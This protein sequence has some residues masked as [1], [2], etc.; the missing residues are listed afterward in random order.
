MYVDGVQMW[1]T[2]EH[3]PQDAAHGGENASF[4]GGMQSNW[5]ASQQ[6]GD[7]VMHVYD[8]S[9]ARPVSSGGD[10]VVTPPANPTLPPPP[11]TAN[12][13]LGTGSDTVVLKISQDAWQGSAQ[14][15]VTVDGTQIGGTLTATALHS[16]GLDDTVTLHGNW[17][18][19]PHTLTVTF[20]NDDWGGSA[21]TDRN[22]YVDSISFNGGAVSGTPIGMEQ[23]GPVNFAFSN[24][25]PTPGP[26]PIP[27]SV[28]L[29]AGSGSDTMVL[30]IS[31]D[32][33]QGSAQY[34]VTVDG[35]QV[36]GTFT[37]TA[38]HGSGVSD[39]L[40]L[41]GDWAAGSHAVA[42]N[43]LNDAWG[44]TAATDRNLYVDSVTYD[45]AAVSGA[46]QAIMG[47]TPGKFTVADS[48]AIPGSTTPAP[49][50]T[51]KTFAGTAGNDTLFATQNNDIITGG[52][53]DDIITARAGN[54]VITGGKG[55]DH[56]TGGK[57][58]DQFVFQAGDGPD[59]IVDFLAGTDQLVLKGFTA[60]QVTTHREV[61]YGTSGLQVD[62]GTDHVFL[63]GTSA[64]K[65]GDIV[66]A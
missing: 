58:A 60:S 10:V 23:N 6:N 66:F 34:T 7:N 61:Y 25:V 16:A 65:A 49:T 44:G 55:N 28:N 62:Y 53:G 39:T 56:I 1:T 52:A 59:W 41:K 11:T 2:T 48:T 51:G 14:Y 3:V 64:L 24:A 15:I 43:F 22:L 32:A 33:W 40:T 21:D 29:A 4:G 27:P 19:G 20:I 13:S 36:G 46:T 5:A 47:S 26:A 18:A 50:P 57:G 63:A 37:A 54:D 17:G 42:V 31:Q 9:Y 35:K 8:I 38:T 30:K 45:G 12:V